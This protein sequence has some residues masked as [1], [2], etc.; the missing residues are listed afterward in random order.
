MERDQKIKEIQIEA[1]TSILDAIQFMDNI[2]ILEL[3]L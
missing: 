3:S 2:Y 1:Q